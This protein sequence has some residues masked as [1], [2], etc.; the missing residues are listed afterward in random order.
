ML[1][2][3]CVFCAKS[4]YHLRNNFT[5]ANSYM[6]TTRNRLQKNRK[7][8]NYTLTVDFSKSCLGTY[9]RFLQISKVMNV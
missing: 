3:I 4:R 9:L 8:L 7:N 2:R 1:R 6:Q 5:Y